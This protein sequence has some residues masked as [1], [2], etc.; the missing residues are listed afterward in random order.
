MYV[1]LLGE[2]DCVRLFQSID[3]LQSQLDDLAALSTAEQKGGFRILDE[4][5]LTF[6]ERPF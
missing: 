3:V 2:L 4:L 1:V 6:F 5:R